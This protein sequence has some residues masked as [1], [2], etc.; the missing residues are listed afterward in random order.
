MMELKNANIFNYDK[1]NREIEKSIIFVPYKLDEAYGATLKSFLKIFIN[2]LPAAIPEKE[3]LLNSSSSFQITGIHEIFG[4]WIYA[5]LTY[6]LN[7]NSFFKSL[8]YKNYEVKGFLNKLNNLFY[9]N[10]MGEK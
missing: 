7:D 4:H 5:Y 8:C 2:R 9:K 3:I 6:K 1:T 10:Q